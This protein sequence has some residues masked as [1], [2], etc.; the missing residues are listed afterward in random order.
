MYVLL[1]KTHTVVSVECGD[2]VDL[3]PPNSSCSLFDHWGVSFPGLPPPVSVYAVSLCLPHRGAA[4][5]P[6]LSL[7][8]FIHPLIV[9]WTFLNTKHVPPFLPLPNMHEIKEVQT[10]LSV[11]D[12]KMVELV[13]H[14]Y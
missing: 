8:G 2:A 3:C 9:K 10:S 1:L 12:H 13:L 14:S 5:C 6:S 7:S 4:P 11:I